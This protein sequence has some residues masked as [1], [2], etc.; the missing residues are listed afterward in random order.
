MLMTRAGGYLKDP[1]VRKAVHGYLDKT[2]GQ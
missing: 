2:Y 1:E